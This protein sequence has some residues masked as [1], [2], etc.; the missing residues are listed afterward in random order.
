MREM[1]PHRRQDAGEEESLSL[2][3]AHNRAR[4]SET[5]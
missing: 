1:R 5:F 3:A 4:R 2:A